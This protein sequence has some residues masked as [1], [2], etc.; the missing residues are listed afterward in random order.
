ML[1]RENLLARRNYC[2]KIRNIL[3]KEGNMSTNEMSDRLKTMSEDRSEALQETIQVIFQ[4]HQQPKFGPP[5][6]EVP[7]MYPASEK[8]S[9][10]TES[11]PRDIINAPAQY[12]HYLEQLAEANCCGTDTETTEPP[13]GTPIYFNSNDEYLSEVTPLQDNSHKIITSTSE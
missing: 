3:S 11:T 12:Q 13:C 6:V 10:L 9:T 2:L 5:Q 1:N 4:D 8:I 7:L